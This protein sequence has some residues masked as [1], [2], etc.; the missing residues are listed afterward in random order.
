[1]VDDG[2]AVDILYLNAYKR[3][4]LIEDELD[5]NSS[6]LYDFTRDHV[7]PKEVLKLTNSGG[8]PSDLDCLCQFPYG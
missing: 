3:M 4:S 2:S 1:M 6:P 5:P 8:T 7:V